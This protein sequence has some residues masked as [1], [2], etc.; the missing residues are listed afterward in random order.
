MPNTSRK[1][2]IYP[3][4]NQ[5]QIINNTFNACRFIWNQM[6]ELSIKSYDDG[7]LRIPNYGDIVLQNSWLS[8]DNKEYRFDRHAA[9]NVKQFLRS[10]FDRYSD[11]VKKGNTKKRK[12][13]KPKS[14][15]RFKSKKYCKNSYTDYNSQRYS[16]FD[17]DNHQIKIPCLGWVKYNPREKEIPNNWIIKHITISKSTT[18]KYYCS[19]CFQYSIDVLDILKNKD[20]NNNILGIDY[21]SSSLYV[22]SEGNKANYPKYYRINQYRLRILHQKFS[23]Q[24]KGGKNREKTLQRIRVLHEKISNQRR[25][26]LHKLSTSITKKFR[27]ICVEDINMRDMSRGLHLGKSTMDNGFGMFREMLSYKQ[28]RIPYHKLILVNQ[29]LFPSSKRCSKCKNIKSEL[30]LSDRIYRCDKCGLTIDRDLNAAI[31]LKQY[32]SEIYDK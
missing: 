31:N 8:K 5:S 12:D 17:F 2:R 25:D 24:Q 22:D 30:K 3:D 10:A 1:I 26:F 18:N 16:K 6:L 7:Q 28:K 14:F 32:G 13:G 19:I 20:N 9:S 11:N 15:P 29:W 21:S 27:I 4:D 23:R